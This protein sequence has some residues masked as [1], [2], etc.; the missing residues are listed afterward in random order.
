MTSGAPDLSVIIVNWNVRELLR[1]C[2]LSLRRSPGFTWLDPSGF[3]PDPKGLPASCSGEIIVVDNASGD[4]SI[5]MLRQDFPSVRVIPNSENRGFSAANNQGLAASTGRY[6]FF[7]NPDTEVVGDA[8]VRMLNYLDLHP[9]AGVVGPRLHY[10]DGALQSSRRRF[11]TFATGIFESTPIAWHRPD[12]RWARRY[13]MDDVPTDQE[14]PVDWLVG[15]ALLARREVLD[16]VGGFDEGYFMYSEELDWCRRVRRAGW[17][18]VYLPDALIVHYEGKSSDQAVA[19]R[20]I[21]FHTSRVRYFRKFHGAVPAMALRLIV[22]FSFAVEWAVEAAKYG[23]GLQ[24]VAARTT[25]GGIPGAASERAATAVRLL[26]RCTMVLRYMRR[27]R[28][29]LA[30]HAAGN[31]ILPLK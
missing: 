19:A 24:A 21:N 5:A 7:L 2:L 12:N 11:P 9:E 14:Q 29:N 17:Q 27:A 22:L 30:L 31:C 13:H 8:V 20:H 3:S 4:G 10:G 15:A 26:V 6:V 16:Q 1:S 28:C 18:I 23:A 25:D